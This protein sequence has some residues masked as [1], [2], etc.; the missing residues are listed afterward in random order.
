QPSELKTLPW[1]MLAPVGG[2]LIIALVLGLVLMRLEADRPLKR[3][4]REAQ[5]LARGE[6]ARLDDDKHPG[7][8]GTVARAGNTTL[9]PLTSTRGPQPRVRNPDA[10]LRSA[11]PAGMSGPTSF[12]PGKPEPPIRTPTPLPPPAPPPPPSSTT[13]PSLFA[14]A[15]DPGGSIHGGPN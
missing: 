14:E 9:D 8:L 11:G 3:M 4:A 1:M 2:G 12:G 5:A 10:V 7:K 6:V 13:T 15:S